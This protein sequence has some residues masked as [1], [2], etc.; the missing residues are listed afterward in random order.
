MTLKKDIVVDYDLLN[1][2]LI[3]DNEMIQL[4]KN[5]LVIFK[6]FPRCSSTQWPIGFEDYLL[7]YLKR[8]QKWSLIFE[9]HP[10]FFDMR[11]NIPDFQNL[12]QRVFS[13]VSIFKIYNDNLNCS[14]T[15]SST[16]LNHL[17]MDKSVYGIRKGD[18]YSEYDEKFERIK[19]PSCEIVQSNFS[20]ISFYG[21][22][23]DDSP[24]NIINIVLKF[25]LSCALHPFYDGNKRTFRAILQIDFMRA[26]FI[27]YPLIPVGP[28][29]HCNLPAYRTHYRRW[30]K[31]G[32]LA[33]LISFVIR[34]INQTL[35]LALSQ[36]RHVK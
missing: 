15:E 31:T 1:K 11:G 12:D 18:A 20:D 26:G 24:K 4:S 22:I 10:A 28:I 8:I 2:S 27:G 35:L 5:T 9:S 33:P 3:I 32:D 6:K 36:I 7:N 13:E 16:I 30:L 21:S 14:F 29:I 17:I 25:L 19:Y 34:L 23:F